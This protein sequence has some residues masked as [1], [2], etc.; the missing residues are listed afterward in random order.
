MSGAPRGTRKR[1]TV[2]LAVLLPLPT[3]YLACRILSPLNAVKIHELDRGAAGSGEGGF[4]IL[5]VG[6]YNIAHGR[7]GREDASKWTDE[8]AGEREER[9]QAIARQIRERNLDVVV[10]NECDFDCNWSRRV[11]QARAIAGAAGYP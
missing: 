4:T 2:V 5:R 11:N 3:W 7:G 9:L 1:L 8:S 10:L 6:C